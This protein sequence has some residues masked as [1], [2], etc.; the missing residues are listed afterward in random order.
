MSPLPAPSARWP[1]ISEPP[2]A[3]RSCNVAP[4][5]TASN[6]NCDVQVPQNFRSPVAAAPRH[7]TVLAIALTNDPSEPLRVAPA[8]AASRWR[9]WQPATEFLNSDSNLVQD[10]HA[11]AALVP[12]PQREIFTETKEERGRE[13]A[14]RGGLGAP[15]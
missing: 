5:A 4:T 3:A 6:L 12:V 1:A 7:D 9:A 2:R 8:D 15:R 13:R 11:V 14:R 10:C